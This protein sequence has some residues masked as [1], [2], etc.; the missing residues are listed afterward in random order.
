MTANRILSAACAI[1]AVLAAAIGAARLTTTAP[2]LP[3]FGVACVL[4]VVAAWTLD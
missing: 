2:A 4:L 3:L 1:S